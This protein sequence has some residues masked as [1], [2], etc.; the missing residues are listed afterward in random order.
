M[1]NKCIDGLHPLLNEIGLREYMGKRIDWNREN[2]GRVSA[3]LQDWYSRPGRFATKGT[4]AVFDRVAAELE[5]SLATDEDRRAHFYAFI[6]AQFIRDYSRGLTRLDGSRSGPVFIRD[7]AFAMADCLAVGRFDNAQILHDQAVQLL[8]QHA[9]TAQKFYA[10]DL[11][12]LKDPG[13][14]VDIIPQRLFVFVHELMGQRAGQAKQPWAKWDIV[15]DQEYIDAARAVYTENS[16]LAAATLCK[17][18]NLHVQYSNPFPEGNNDDH[19]VGIE[20]DT[21][22]RSLWPAEIFAWLRLR[23]E[24]G[25]PLPEREHPLLEQSLGHFDPGRDRGWQPEPWFTEFVEKLVQFNSRYKDLPNL[26]F[27]AG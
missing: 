23:Q 24:R 12:R 4:N 25:L 26:V 18:C 5:V 19:L 9:Y 2:I 20:F 17:L 15:G 3:R 11:E 27:G 21:P 13:N 10:E 14:F 8:D 6:I 7:S 22:I 1:V 16:D